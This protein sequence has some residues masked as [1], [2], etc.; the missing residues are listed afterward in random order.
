MKSF[1]SISRSIEKEIQSTMLVLT[2]STRHRFDQFAG[3]DLVDYFTRQSV[4]IN[5]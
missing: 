5:W 2:S 3:K 4:E 1:P